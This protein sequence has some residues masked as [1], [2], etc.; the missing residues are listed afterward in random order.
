[1]S[2]ASSSA[3]LVS[4][5]GR[6]SRPRVV[7]P[8]TSTHV[9]RPTEGTSLRW[10][11][12]GLLERHKYHLTPGSGTP[13][14][15]ERRGR[16]RGE[17]DTG[18]GEWTL[19]STTPDSSSRGRASEVHDRSMKEAPAATRGPAESGRGDDCRSTTETDRKNNNQQ[20]L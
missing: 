6:G 8:L 16:D 4:G 7:V 15:W 10:V 12:Q 13:V 17:E 20:D 2:S 1:M 3:R 18:N 14:P 19:E 11:V 9:L 5:V